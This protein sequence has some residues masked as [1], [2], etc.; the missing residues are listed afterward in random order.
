[1]APIPKQIWRV[2]GVGTKKTQ[3]FYKIYRVSSLKR[4]IAP[5]QLALADRIMNN[6]ELCLPGAEGPGGA[7][8][9]VAKT[10]LMYGGSA[11]DLISSAYPDLRVA[12]GPGR[13]QYRHV[14]VFLSA[15]LLLQRSSILSRLHQLPGWHLRRLNDR[16]S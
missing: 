11:P 13:L 4:P 8:F 14:D 1:M 7:R 5:Q 10:K 16:R 6:N 3:H 9:I 2:Q 12:P 15:H